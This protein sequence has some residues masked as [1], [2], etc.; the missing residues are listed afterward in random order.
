MPAGESA[1]VRYL[2]VIGR[3]Y[4]D[5]RLHLRPC[6]LTT[7]APWSDREGVGDSPL[8]AELLTERGES[9]GRYPLRVYSPCTYDGRPATEAVRGW[10]PF[11]PDTRAV[12][13]TH[14]DRVVLEIRRAE[15]PPEVALT[16]RPPDEIHGRHRVTWEARSPRDAA[17]QFLLRYSHDGGRRWQR[18]GWRTEARDATVDFDQ[19]PGG[20]R[21]LVAVVA[22]DGVDTTTVESPPFAVALKRCQAFIVAPVDGAVVAADGPMQLL[23]QGFWMEESRVER[24]HLRWTSSLDGDLG[25]GASVRVDRLSEGQHRIT[26]AAGENGRVGTETVTI[27]VSGGARSRPETAS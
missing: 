1:A 21:C 2:R 23:G 20:E 11:H 26:L 8:A 13:F 22:T 12:R 19:L 7:Q 15:R 10:V 9:L 5:G 3:L 16:W 24:D 14:R 6:Y 17:L 27:T 18:V 4:R 25:R